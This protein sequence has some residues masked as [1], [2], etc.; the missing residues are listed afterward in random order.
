MDIFLALFQSSFWASLITLASHHGFVFWLPM[1]LSRSSL[2]FIRNSYRM[3]LWSHERNSIILAAKHRIENY[4]FNVLSLQWKC[5]CFL[6]C[7]SC[8][9]PEVMRGWNIT[10][11][12]MDD[13]NCHVGWT[14]QIG[15]DNLYRVQSL[16]R[17]TEF[18]WAGF[19]V[20]YIKDLT[21]EQ[22]IL[23]LLCD[24]IN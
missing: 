2:A 8:L 6:M 18:I 13:F 22:A 1:C 19:L 11:V 9:V 23:D 16:Y 17:V 21:R 14:N 12:G 20:Q 15:M 24:R 7:T 5:F 4:A 10:A 3:T